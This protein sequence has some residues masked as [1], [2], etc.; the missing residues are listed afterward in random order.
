MKS[1][2]QADNKESAKQLL[3][4]VLTMCLCEAPPAVRSLKR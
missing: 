2:E 3:Q 1:S 4:K